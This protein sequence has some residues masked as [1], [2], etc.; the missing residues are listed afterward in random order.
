MKQLSILGLADEMAQAKARKKEF[1]AQMGAII[2]WDECVEFISPYFYKGEVGNKSFE[3][4]LMLRIHLLQNMY[5]LSDMGARL[6]ILDSRASSELCGVDSSVQVLD[7]DA[8][9]RFRTLLVENVLQ[10]MLF[11]QVVVLLEI[12]RFRQLYSMSVIVCCRIRYSVLFHA[13][14]I[15][16]A[17]YGSIKSLVP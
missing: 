2:P 7:G 16:A 3:L 4:H 9:G 13:S 15:H 14:I 8:I 10:E 12:L 11:L 6:E 17:I 1:L 5:S